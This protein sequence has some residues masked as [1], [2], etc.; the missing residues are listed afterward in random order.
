MRILSGIQP[1]GKLHLGNYFGMMRS[2]FQLQEQGEAFLRSQVAMDPG[3]AQVGEFSLTDK[4]FSRINAFM[5][6]TLFDE[7]FGGPFG[8]CH[9]A[10]GSSHIESFSGKASDLDKRR[11]RA[12]GFNESALHWDLVNTREKTVT[13]PRLVRDV[14]FASPKPKPAWTPA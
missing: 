7:N 6:N 14:A 3:A 12:L 1:S 4:R 13:A 2:A 8:N 10:L 5:A 9:L 11:K